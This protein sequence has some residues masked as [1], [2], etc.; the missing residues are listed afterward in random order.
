MAE[1][2]PL[3]NSAVLRRVKRSQP[4]ELVET[5][6]NLYPANASS[7]VGSLHN[8]GYYQSMMSNTKN[9]AAISRLDVTEVVDG[10][11][12]E[13]K[14][15]DE[16]QCQIYLDVSYQVRRIQYRGGAEHVLQSVS[17]PPPGRQT[18]FRAM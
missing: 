5:D 15:T 9:Y 16:A 7:L 8:M 3:P 11:T 12:I 14:L 10:K 6:F 18:T 1:L 17:N 4:D 13:R 2:L